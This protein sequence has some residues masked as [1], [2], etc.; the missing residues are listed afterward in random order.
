MRD[1]PVPLHGY[2]DMVS[3]L[4]QDVVPCVGERK[5]MLFEDYVDVS[6]TRM[7]CVDVVDLGCG[8]VGEIADFVDEL[9]FLFA[10]LVKLGLC[11]RDPC[12]AQPP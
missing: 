6:L 4:F 7:F 8:V 1:I 12:N 10:S 11:L 2:E 5:A 3:P 9:P